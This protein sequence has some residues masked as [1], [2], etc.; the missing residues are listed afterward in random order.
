[1]INRLLSFASL[2]AVLCTVAPHPVLVIQAAAERA[3]ALATYM[4][5][6][7]ALTASGYLPRAAGGF[8]PEWLVATAEEWASRF[9][10]PCWRTFWPGVSSSRPPLPSRAPR[11]SRN[12][13]PFDPPAFAIEKPAAWFD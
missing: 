12:P 13:A 3:Q 11:S 7:D 8:E 10:V 6:V 1:M 4:R 5:V 2:S 9:R